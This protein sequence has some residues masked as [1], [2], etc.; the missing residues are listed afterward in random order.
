MQWITHSARRPKQHAW[1]RR[2]QEAWAIWRSC[3]NPAMQRH[4]QE[5]EIITE[6][7]QG[8]T[9]NVFNGKLADHIFQ[10]P[11]RD[12]VTDLPKKFIARIIANKPSSWVWSLKQ[13][14]LLFA[15]SDYEWKKW[16]QPFTTIKGRMPSC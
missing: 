12:T 16:P 4:R 7:R 13:L 15:E 9:W 1:S 11:F 6:P 3:P 10:S 5:N 8:R 14:I 2:Y